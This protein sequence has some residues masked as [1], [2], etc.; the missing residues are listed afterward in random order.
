MNERIIVLGEWSEASSHKDT[1]KWFRLFPVRD[2]PLR[3]ISLNVFFSA[4]IGR[5]YPLLYKLY[6][7]FTVYR[8]PKFQPP[9]FFGELLAKKFLFSGIF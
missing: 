1:S 5:I 6:D 7:G 4:P 8:I 2:I 9:I 3:F